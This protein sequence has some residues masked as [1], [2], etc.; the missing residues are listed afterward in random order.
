M[1]S[2]IASIVVVLVYVIFVWCRIGISGAEAAVVYGAAP[3]FMIWCADTIGSYTE[4]KEYGGID[5]ATPGC[6]IQF[7]GWLF[8]IFPAVWWFFFR[9]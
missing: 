8:L 4:P 1:I 7:I 2:R 3:L 6:I 5:K 9:K